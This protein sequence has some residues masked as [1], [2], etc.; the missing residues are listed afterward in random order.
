MIS[1][2]Y[3]RAGKKRDVDVLVMLK[4][5]GGPGFDQQKILCMTGWFKPRS[6]DPKY[7]EYAISITY[8]LLFLLP[9]NERQ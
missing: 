4:C 7:V 8:P 5:N 9:Q 2:A 6:A 1:G 3:K